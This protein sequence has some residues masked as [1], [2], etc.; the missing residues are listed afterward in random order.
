MF[1][2]SPGVEGMRQKVQKYDKKKI[3]SYLQL[4]GDAGTSLFLQSKLQNTRNFAQNKLEK[5]LVTPLTVP[6]LLF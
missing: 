2:E 6:Q 1:L 5:F 4:L 3:V